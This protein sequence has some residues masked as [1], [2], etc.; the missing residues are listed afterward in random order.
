ML[1][2]ACAVDFDG[3]GSLLQHAHQ[4]LHSHIFRAIRLSQS[5]AVHVVCNRA[6][7]G[8]R[9]CSS[10]LWALPGV[11][12]GRDPAPDGLPLLRAAAG[13]LALRRPDGAFAVVRRGARVLAAVLRPAGPGA[14]THCPLPQPENPELACTRVWRLNSAERDHTWRPAR[15]SA[16]RAA[17]SGLSHTWQRRLEN[18][19]RH[20]IGALGVQARMPVQACESPLLVAVAAGSL[21][22]PTLLK[23]AT[24]MAGQTQDFLTCSQLP[25]VSASSSTQQ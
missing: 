4:V 13:G 2:E 18:C 15:R 12:D 5:E 10:Q 17:H 24:V 9:V 19:A 1:M 22:L 23:L 8:P 25:V 14:R 20:A 16:A 3:Q 11:G 6:N 21:A 7:Q